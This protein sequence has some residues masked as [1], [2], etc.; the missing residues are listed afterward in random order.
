[1]REPGAVEP[2]ELQYHTSASFTCVCLPLSGLRGGGGGGGGRVTLNRVELGG[3]RGDGDGG[4]GG[5]GGGGYAPLRIPR[6]GFD[7]FL[8][9]Q[10][11][12]HKDMTCVTTRYDGNSS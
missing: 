2:L 5:R 4:E 10:V 6:R 7:R 3:G 11:V 9:A 8:P 12:S 1:M